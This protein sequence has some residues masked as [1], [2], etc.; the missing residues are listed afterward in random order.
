MIRIGKYN[1][2][3]KDYEFMKRFILILL[4]IYFE[5]IENIDVEYVREVLFVSMR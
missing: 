1:Y 5:L 3:E 2:S 4:K